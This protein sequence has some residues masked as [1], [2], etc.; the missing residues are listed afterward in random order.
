M[1]EIFVPCP[2]FDKTEP[3]IVHLAGISYCDG[4]YKIKRTNAS[5]AC[6]EYVMSGVGTIIKDT[7]VYPEKGDTYFLPAGE[8][9]EY[10][11][12]SDD[13]WTKIWINVSGPLVTS[14]IDAYSLHSQSVFHCNTEKYFR[15]IHKILTIKEYSSQ[16]IA[17]QIAIIFHK[18]I[19]AIAHHKDNEQSLSADAVT[20]KNYIDKNIYRQITIDELSKLIYKSPAHTIRIF[21]NAYGVTPYKYF[22][23]NKIK[24]ATHLLRDTHFSIKNIA[25]T[26]GFCDEHYFTNIFKEKTGKT[27]SEYRK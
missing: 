21:K 9:H 18:L 7:P 5:F 2:V 14:L 22:T 10:F 4:S 15:E 20:V 26:L 25:L 11:S 12:S 24:K 8:S 27:P 23:D 13:P 19:Q 16:E 1:E 6:F 17:S 3:V